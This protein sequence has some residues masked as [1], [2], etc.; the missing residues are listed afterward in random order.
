MIEGATYEFLDIYQNLLFDIIS[1]D[2][3]IQTL[4]YEWM[5]STT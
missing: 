2:N 5:K 4:M 3:P 1:V